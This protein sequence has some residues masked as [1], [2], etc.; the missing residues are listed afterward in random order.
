MQA[1]APFEMARPYDLLA[2]LNQDTR[3]ETIITIYHDLK[4]RKE[5]IRRLWS[6]IQRDGDLDAKIRNDNNC[7]EAGFLGS[8]D[9]YSSE[10]DDGRSKGKIPFQYFRPSKVNL[11]DDVD[12]PD[13]KKISSLTF[14]MHSF[15]HLEVRLI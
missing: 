3:W 2:F 9:W 7:V 5:I 10:L 6:Y 8:I 1:G 14:S 12:V 13:C 4:S 11:G 15:E